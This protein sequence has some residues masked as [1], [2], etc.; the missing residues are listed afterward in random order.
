MIKYLSADLRGISKEQVT[1]HHTLNPVKTTQ[2]STYPINLVVFIEWGKLISFSVDPGGFSIEKGLSLMTPAR[3]N[4]TEQGLKR[5]FSCS[6][7]F[8]ISFIRSHGDMERCPKYLATVVQ[9]LD[10]AIPRINQ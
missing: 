8:F 7:A 3:N 9:M 4:E 6:W 5:A 2:G 1:V 10:N